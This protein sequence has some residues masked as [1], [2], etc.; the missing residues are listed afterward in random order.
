MRVMILFRKVIGPNI[1]STEYNCL[2]AAT[3]QVMV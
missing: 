1:E 3:F 2:T